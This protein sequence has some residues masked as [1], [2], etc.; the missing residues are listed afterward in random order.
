M[1]DSALRPLYFKPRNGVRIVVWSTFAALLLLLP[2]VARSSFAQTLLCATGI[3]AIACMSYNMLLGQAGMLSFGHAVYTG[4]AAFVAAHAMN[5]V[6]AGW[7]VPMWAIPLVGGLAG[8]AFGVVLGYI[9]TRKA[10]TPFA[11]ITLGVGELAFAGALMFPEFFGGEAGISAN[12]TAGSGWLKDIGITFGPQLQVYYLIAIYLFLCSAAMYAFT[13][14][15]LGRIA[16]A[17]RDNAERAEF[18]G[19]DTRWVRYLVVMASSFF[20]G[21]AGGLTAINV[22]AATADL[23]HGVRSGQ[24]LLFTFLGGVGFFFGPLIGSVLL[25]FALVVLSELTKAWQLYVG[26]VFLIMVVYAPGGFAALLMLNLRRIKYGEW[27]KMR[28]PYAGMVFFGVIALWGFAAIVEMLYQVQDAAV[29]GSALSV[30][31]IKLD[32]ATVSSWVLA[33]AVLMVGAFGFEVWRRRFKRVW[34]DGEERIAEAIK[35]AEAAIV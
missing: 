31:G 25:V 30:A 23:L 27:R 9:T 7:W 3:A 34:D 17:V 33:V 32:S 24:Y 1:T 13:L 14:T 28:W 16:N 21:I 10:G 6:A 19:Y 5:R 35:K 15:P 8:L 12:R 18:V 22:E 4:L 29:T 11:M 2:L 20:A 26:I